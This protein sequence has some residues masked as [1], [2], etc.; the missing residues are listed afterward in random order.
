MDSVENIFWW[1]GHGW[2]G[3]VRACGGLR[4]GTLYP[5]PNH[6][7]TQIAALEALFKT[8]RLCFFHMLV[9]FED[10]LKKIKGLVPEQR[11]QILRQLAEMICAPDEAVFQLL[12]TEFIAAYSQSVPGIIKYYKDNWAAISKR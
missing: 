12:E 5:A 9:N 10:N 7:L 2:W 1:E 6:H 3:W 4:Y 11:R 8:I